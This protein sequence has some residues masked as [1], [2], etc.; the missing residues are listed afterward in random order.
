MIKVVADLM[1]SHEQSSFQVLLQLISNSLPL[2]MIYADM[3]SD[4][5]TSSTNE[6][7]EEVLE[8]ATAL[9]Q[10]LK[11]P[12]AELLKLDPLCRYPQHHAEILEKFSDGI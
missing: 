9:R 2:D 6:D 5:K 11:L 4:G 1:D 12:I 10:V 7:F 8:L 3:C